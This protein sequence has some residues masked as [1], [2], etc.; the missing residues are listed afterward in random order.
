MILQPILN[1][2]DLRF[3][4]QAGALTRFY[5]DALLGI[6]PIRSHSATRAVHVEHES[7]LV[8]WW[9]TGHQL[10]RANLWISGVQATIANCAR[11]DIDRALPSD[12]EG[13]QSHVLLL[14]FWAMG[15]PTLAQGFVKSLQVFPAYAQ[16]QPAA[17]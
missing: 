14:A 16:L 2:R 8:E 6:T 7:M 5:L 9:R 4:T 15:L 12:R 11:A 10:L 3:R 13:E 17:A 1:E